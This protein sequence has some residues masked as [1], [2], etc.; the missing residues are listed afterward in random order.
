MTKSNFLKKIHEEEKLELVQISKEMSLS[1]EKKA[2]ECREVAKLAF[3]NNYYESA[4]TQS[5]YS[6]YN[7]CLSIFFL[8]G[9]KC[10]NHSACAILLK[11]IYENNELFDLFSEMKTERIDKQYYTS[12]SENTL[13]TKEITKDSINKMIKF[14]NKI[15][16]LKINLKNEEI[17]KIRDKLNSFFN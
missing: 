1:Y 10:E 15:I 13:L 9:I 6:M 11:D 12:T 3:K 5:Y 8:C 17:N 2:I 4:V 14:N 16:S 7:N